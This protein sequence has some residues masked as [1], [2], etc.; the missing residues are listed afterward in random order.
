MVYIIPKKS[1]PEHF[2]EI[3]TPFVKDEIRNG[4]GFLKHA[5]K[6]AEH[7]DSVFSFSLVPINDQQSLTLNNN[8]D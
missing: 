4:D 3:I 6:M 7:K 2:E 1:S 8:S 5:Q